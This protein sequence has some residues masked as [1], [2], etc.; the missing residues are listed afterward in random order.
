[1]PSGDEPRDE[2][3]LTRRET[4]AAMALQGL[5]ANTSHHKSDEPKTAI[6]LAV[7]YADGLIKELDKSQYV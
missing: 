6:T 3:Q 4:I 7:K 2:Y 1:M 5:L